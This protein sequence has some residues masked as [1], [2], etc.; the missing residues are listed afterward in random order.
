MVQVLFETEALP[1]L[2]QGL[3]AGAVAAV[4]FYSPG[5]GGGADLAVGKGGIEQGVVKLFEFG[6]GTG[7]EMFLVGVGAEGVEGGGGDA[8]LGQ[9]GQEFLARNGG[10]GFMDWW[11]NL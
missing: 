8:E 7:G 5:R 4:F 3:D 2:A 10:H 1:D 11:I 9:Q 6:E